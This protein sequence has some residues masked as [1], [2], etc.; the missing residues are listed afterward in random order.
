MLPGTRH[1]YAERFSSKAIIG[2]CIAAREVIDGDAGGGYRTASGVGCVTGMEDGCEDVA[3]GASQTLMSPSWPQVA[4]ELPS[5]LNFTHM[6]GA[7]WA[8]TL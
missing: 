1:F 8:R 3:C 7:S 2:G 6:S 5:G 4:M